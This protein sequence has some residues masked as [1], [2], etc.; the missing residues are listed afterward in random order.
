M[1]IQDFLYMWRGKEMAPL[2]PKEAY[3]LDA[4][5]SR[6][7]KYERALLLLHGFA[8]SPAVYRELLPAFTAYDAV[9]CPPLPGHGSSIAAF[10]NAKATDWLNA[11]HHACESLIKQ[12]DNVD[13]LGLSLGGLLAC[14]LSEHFPLN[15][16]YLLA[17]ALALKKNINLMLAGLTVLQSLGVKTLK[18]R[19]GNIQ[20]NQFHELT[21]RHLPLN[22]IRETLT[23]I[24]QFKF[25][26]PHCPVDVFLGRFDAVVDSKR[27]GQYFN[28]LPNAQIHWLNH[29]AHVLPIDGDI[30]MLTHFFKHHA[31]KP[32]DQL[33]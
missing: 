30:E 25:T 5:D 3:L 13:V 29:S 23:L 31:Q 8:S 21:Y 4:I 24:K 20:S 15:H 9:V 19:A 7:E 28:G 22:A 33:L 27:V 12:Y 17:P 1:N 18:N 32:S 6:G 16:L 11:A 2:T 10:S 14:H 26:P